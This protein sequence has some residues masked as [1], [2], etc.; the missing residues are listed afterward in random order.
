MHLREKPHFPKCVLL[1]LLRVTAGRSQHKLG[2][3]YLTLVQLGLGGTSVGDLG[4]KY[5]LRGDQL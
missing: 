4:A 3:Q 5:S 2:N 1:S